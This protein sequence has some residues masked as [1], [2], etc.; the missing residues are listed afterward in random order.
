ME[1]IYDIIIIGGGP[2]GMT[3]TLYAC[4]QNKK[5]LLLE[6]DFFG[7][8]ASRSP[9]IENFP[10]FDGTGEELMNKFRSSLRRLDNFQVEFEE[11][12]KI[13]ST[14][15]PFSWLVTTSD[16]KVY[17]TLYIIFATG[18]KHKKLNIPNEEQLVKDGVLSYCTICDGKFFIDGVTAV[19]GDSFSAAQYALDLAQ[20]C[21]RVH[22]VALGNEL[23]CE[24]SMTERIK[25]TPN[26]EIHYNYNTTKIEYI[27]GA[28]KELV[29]LWNENT[30]KYDVIVNGIFVA[31]GRESNIDPEIFTNENIRRAMFNDNG[32]IRVECECPVQ[33][34]VTGL[35]AAG[36]CIDKNSPRQVITAASEGAMAALEI[37]KHLNEV[38]VEH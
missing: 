24:E 35:Y 8:Q 1:T 30:R 14:T 13:E 27:V 4:R 11:A 20:Y 38:E 29:G 37:V 15:E 6:K 10:G 25:N 3:A 5:V 26:I 31:I 18:L 21:R 32:M 22:L 2:A 9:H 7:G 19:I 36:D 34:Y 33:C 17:K 16:G 28:N 23:Y 12:V